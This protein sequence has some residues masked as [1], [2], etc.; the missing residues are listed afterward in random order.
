[1]LTYEQTQKLLSILEETLHNVQEGYEEADQAED[2]ATNAYEDAEN[3][4]DEA[5]EAYD[6]INDAINSAARAGDYA[7]ESMSEA[8]DA[9]CHAYEARLAVER[10]ESN[11]SDMRAILQETID[12]DFFIKQTIERLCDIQ[13]A[14]LGLPPMWQKDIRELHF[15]RERERAENGEACYEDFHEISTE[16][17]ILDSSDLQ[18]LDCSDLEE[19]N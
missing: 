8:E 9:K 4:S 2:C 15:Q 12:N 19:D 1:M 3:A 14:L 11:L 6:L 10:A 5:N 18:D 17:T 13:E 7:K 16:D